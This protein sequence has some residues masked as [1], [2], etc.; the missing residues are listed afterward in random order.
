M[1]TLFPNLYSRGVRFE[2]FFVAVTQTPIASAGIEVYQKL[3]VYQ[4]K[5]PHYHV[6]SGTYTFKSY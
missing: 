4:K 6:T 3:I 5:V 2:F 1:A